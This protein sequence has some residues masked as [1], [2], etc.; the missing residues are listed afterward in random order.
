MKAL[1]SPKP[2]LKIPLRKNNGQFKSK[3][4]KIARRT[5]IIVSVV[6]LGTL[7]YKLVNI[8]QPTQPLVIVQAHNVKF[9]VESDKAPVTMYT[10]R[11]EETDNSPCTAASGKDICKLYAT[12]QNVCA[13]NDY[14]I[15]TRLTVV[16]LGDCLVLDRM[17]SRYNRTGAV[18]WYTG[19]DLQRARSY[20][21]QFIEVKRY[22]LSD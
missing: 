12:G 17:N 4:S 19:M 18:D 8:V 11:L 20:G 22:V 7:L 3:M 10:S 9:Y 14:P 21:K 1:Y 6:I 2:R 13:S 15:G 16:G 5:I